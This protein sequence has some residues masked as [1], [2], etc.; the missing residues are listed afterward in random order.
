MRKQARPAE[1]HL[2]QR[3]N[4]API[5]LYCN[6]CGAENPDTATFCAKCGASLWP[7]VSP[8]SSTT[9]VTPPATVSSSS[10]S[11]GGQGGYSSSG[12]GSTSGSRKASYTIGSAF[13]DAW[14]LV[15]NPTGFMNANRDNDT[16]LRN[17][18][19]NYVAIL[20]AIPFVATLIGDSIFHLAFG[21]L[22]FGFGFAL[23]IL[24]YILD[25][26]AV[27]VVG[28]V[29][30][31]LGPS[32]GTTTT[33]IR[34]TRLA[35]YIFTPVFLLSIFDIVPFLG[36][37]A[38]L[39]VLYGLYILYLGMPIVLN[40]PKDRVITY[41]IVTIVVTFVVYAIIGA[42]IG[43]IALALFLGSLGIFI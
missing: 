31:K 2:N 36:I 34:A 3:K 27:F 4:G 40:T 24:T 38:I 43:A 30:W 26:V 5:K 21:A 13:S 9:P 19:I 17:L 37:I 1:S 6:K 28:F 35:A 39:G 25:I 33:Q 32:F 22:A 18:M 20:A 16:S 29:M 7:T 8:S 15:R 14:E 42:I 23:A 41:L 11:S 12:V 10:S